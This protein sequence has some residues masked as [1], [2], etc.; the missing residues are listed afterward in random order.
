MCK[1]QGWIASLSLLCGFRYFV[2][3]LAMTGKVKGK[4]IPCPK[5]REAFFL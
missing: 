5:E 4:E 2:H 1:R 3:P